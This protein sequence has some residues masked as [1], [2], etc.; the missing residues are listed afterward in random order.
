MINDSFYYGILFAYYKELL[1]EKQKE[2]LTLY[3]EQNFTINEIAIEYQVSK[4]SVFDLIKRVNNKL[5][6]YEEKLALYEKS[7]EIEKLLQDLNLSE[8]IIERITEII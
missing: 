6:V 7:L 1:T 4:E 2:Y 8:E 5:K 3:Y